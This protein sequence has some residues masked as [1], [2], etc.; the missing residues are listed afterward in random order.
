MSALPFLSCPRALPSFSLSPS[1]PAFLQIF[2][3]L[4]AHVRACAR[5]HLDPHAPFAN[6]FSPLRACGRACV[7]ACVRVNVCVCV[8]VCVRVVSARR[9][10]CL[11]ACACVRACQHT[12]SFC[13]LICDCLRLCFPLYSDTGH[14]VSLGAPNEEH[15]GLGLFTQPL[16][17][18]GVYACV[19]A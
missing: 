3:P 9:A 18:N 10:C 17:P 13:A 5:A 2:S 12:G 8:C 11:C 4:H 7:Q 14:H 16:F 15:E 6:L 1:S 19:H